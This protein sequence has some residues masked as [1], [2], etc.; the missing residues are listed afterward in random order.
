MHAWF[1]VFCYK[2]LFFEFLVSINFFY[3]IHRLNAKPSTYLYNS[4][5]SE[6][7]LVVQRFISNFDYCLLISIISNW[8]MFFKFVQHDTQCK[9]HTTLNP[10][11]ENRGKDRP[12]WTPHV[13][14]AVA[15]HY[16]LQIIFLLPQVCLSRIFP[17][18]KR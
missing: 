3:P 7:T 14:F 5:N 13:A 9:Q 10:Q 8:L 18:C 1:S 15:S 16:R 4:F 11:F 12:A 6:F 2:C 17:S